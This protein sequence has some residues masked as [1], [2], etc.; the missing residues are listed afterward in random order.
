[1]GGEVAPFVGETVEVAGPFFSFLVEGVPAGVILV[2]LWG[3]EFHI[4]DFNLFFES[5]DFLFRSGDLLF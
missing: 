1:M 2:G 4:A 5:G 3:G